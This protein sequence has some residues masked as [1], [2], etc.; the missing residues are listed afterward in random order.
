M[1][2]IYRDQS[3]TFSENF[4]CSFSDRYIRQYFRFVNLFLTL[5]ESSLLMA[6]LCPS[7]HHGCKYFTRKAASFCFR[8]LCNY[9]GRALDF[10]F[11]YGST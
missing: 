8:A 5:E 7:S 6:T 3:Y 1:K 9:L 2:V 11:L 4:T 10:V